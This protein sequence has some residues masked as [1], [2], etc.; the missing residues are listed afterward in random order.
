MDGNVLKLEAQL[1]GWRLRIARLAGAV[2]GVGVQRDFDA[3]V[4]IDELK[5][6][7]AVAWSKLDEF[8]AARGGDRG[9]LEDGLKSAWDDLEAAVENLDP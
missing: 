7:H 2:H 9:H 8:K 5:L 6:L 4:Y 1:R 3:L